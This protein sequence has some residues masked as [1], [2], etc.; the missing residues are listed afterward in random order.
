MRAGWSLKEASAVL[1]IHPRRVMQS[2]DPTLARMA[3]LWRADSTRTMASLL[4]AVAELDELETMTDREL[5]LR[6][7]LA[8]LRADRVTLRHGWRL[9]E[10][11]V[12]LGIHPRRLMQSLA[13]TLARMARLWRADATR[14]MA[15]LMSAVADLDEL[16]P[17]TEQELALRIEMATGRAD[18]SAI[19]GHDGAW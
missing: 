13:P 4:L 6:I 9:K 10:A 12:V 16:E 11:A 15:S 5:A 7:E 18:R 3:R 19:H 1:G 17:M 2:L 14:T 8:L